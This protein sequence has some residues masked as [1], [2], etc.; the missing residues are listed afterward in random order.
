MSLEPVYTQ[1]TNF[2]KITVFPIYLDSQSSPEE[3]H[4]LWAYHVRIENLGTETIQLRTRHWIITDAYGRRQE[5]KGTGVIGETPT[6][7]PGENF[8]YT[9]GTP[10]STPSGIMMGHYEMEKLNGETFLVDIPAFSLD[11]PHQAVLLN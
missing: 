9:S 1:T 4:Y 8:E 11:S 6:I 3:N 2:V 10:L 7:K 5:I